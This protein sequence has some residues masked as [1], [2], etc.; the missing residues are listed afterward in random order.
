MAKPASP[1]FGG[2]IATGEN[3]PSP[4]CGGAN[5]TPIEGGG[6]IATDDVLLLE[7]L[8]ELAE[9]PLELLVELEE[10]LFR[11]VAGRG[12]AEILAL[13]FVTPNAGLHVIGMLIEA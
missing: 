9:L 4:V 10:L 5:V 6:G 13:E 2:W 12:V 11:L 1:V 3:P 7:L 8:L